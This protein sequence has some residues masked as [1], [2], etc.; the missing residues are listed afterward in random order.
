VKCDK[1]LEG[2][3]EKRPDMLSEKVMEKRNAV[4][5][6]FDQGLAAF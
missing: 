2:I 1:N 4:L 6:G 3:R 5:H